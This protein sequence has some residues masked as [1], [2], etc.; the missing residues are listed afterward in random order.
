MSL[1]VAAVLCRHVCCWKGVN[2]SERDGTGL[3]KEFYGIYV[4]V[5]VELYGGFF[6]IWQ[7]EFSWRQPQA[8]ADY[9]SEGES[10][11]GSLLCKSAMPSTS[12]LLSSSEPAGLPRYSHPEQGLQSRVRI[13]SALCCPSARPSAALAPGRAGNRAESSPQQQRSRGR[14]PFPTA[15]A[16]GAAVFGA[17]GSA[18][19]ETCS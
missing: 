11:D 16:R 6:C 12:C 15:L 1:L 3:P 7:E 8:G 14:I 10:L 13:P 2:Y 5:K 19:S 9:L 17:W 18:G 4:V